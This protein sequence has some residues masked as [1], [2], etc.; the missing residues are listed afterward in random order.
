[1]LA[2]SAKVVVG[3]LVIALMASLCG[4]WYYVFDNLA[5]FKVYFAVAFLAC[6]I[7]LLVTGQRWWV[8]VAGM[9]FIVNFGAIAP[10]YL[11]GS[12]VAM[13]SSPAEDVL[14]V[15]LSNV[16]PRNKDHTSLAKLITE[17]DP[18]LLGL[19]EITPDHLV[20]LSSV[21]ERYPYSLAVPK[22]G[23]WGFA[24]FSKRPLLNARLVD[25]GDGVPPAIVA[26][27]GMGE[28]SVEVILA[29]PF[30]PMDAGLASLRNVE[31]AR[32]ADYIEEIGS[33]TLVIGDLN[34]TMWSHNYKLLIDEADLRNAREGHGI[35]GT[36][37]AIPGVGV[38]LDHILFTHQF[39]A[40]AF[41]VLPGVGSD[42]FPVAATIALLPAARLEGA[43]GLKMSAAAG[44]SDAGH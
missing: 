21:V 30:P 12:A 19:V 40:E 36:W 11:Q 42:H 24:L 27:I 18:D 4:R 38:P 3:I 5:S 37:P 7:V 13:A 35:G 34:A 2:T 28:V 1:M 9:G 6:T 39:R 10:W 26:S 23:F 17:E 25:F 44:N 33:P 29:H 14:T 16:S 8:L 32:I 15:M 20:D 31:L 43:D 41:R 22:D